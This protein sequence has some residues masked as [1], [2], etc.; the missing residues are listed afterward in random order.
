MSAYHKET[1]AVIE[2]IDELWRVMDAQTEP[3]GADYPM[4][5]IEVIRALLSAD[6]EKAEKFHHA[7]SIGFAEWKETFDINHPHYAGPK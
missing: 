5:M 6:F 2:S 7:M 1:R 4:A 3:Y